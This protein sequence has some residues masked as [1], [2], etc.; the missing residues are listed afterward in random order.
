M[1]EREALKRQIELLQDLINKHR[2]VHGD[3]PI[4]AAER[5]P[6]EAPT[7]ARGR[8]F[9]TSFVHP[10]SSRGRPY[11]HQSCGSWRKTYSLRNNCP[12]ST[13]RQPSAVPSTSLHPS[14]SQYGTGS[15]SAT[16]NSK[17]PEANLSKTASSLSGNLTQKKEGITSR[18]IG[19][20]G[21]ATEQLNT[22]SETQRL[23]SGST[24]MQGDVSKTQEGQ[25][26]GE[27][28]FVILP[29]KKTGASFKFPSSVST[30][31]LHSQCRIQIQNKSS[32]NNKTSP[33]TCKTNKSPTLPTLS[34]NP[35]RPN[36]LSPSKQP[37]HSFQH[38]SSQTLHGQVNAPFLKKSKFTWVNNQTV[39]L[40]LKATSSVSTPISR[41]ARSPTSVLKAAVTVGSPLSGALSK[42]TPFRKFPRKLSPVTVAPKTSMYR[43]V[44]S[45]GVQTKNQRKPLS[46]KTVTVPQ[47]S[48]ER[49]DVDKKLKS[50]F[51]PSARPKRE[52]A[53]SSASST[54][55]SRYRWKAG[56]Q[57]AAGSG[58]GTAAVARRRSTFHWTAE[59]S[60]KGLK[61]G[62]VSPTYPQRAYLRSPPPS[63]FTLHSRMKIIRRTASSVGG[64]EKTST[65]A[66]GKFPP[67]SR[68]HT[69]SRS[70]AGVRRTPSK[71]LVCF[72][73]HKLRKIPPTF[74]K[75]S[76][77]PLSKFKG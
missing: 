35:T 42:K 6:P 21:A 46:P 50:T 63:V 65:L 73:R 32:L 20:S 31:S 37:Q 62:H 1:E 38:A 9:S 30:D 58:T 67:R 55:V 36:L 49:G 26:K 57:I 44:S 68:L 11:D 23:S 54:L 4:T 59:K 19:M 48:L 27:N 72:G 17:S 71:E 18:K 43:W 14:T 51:S 75:T 70:P 40:E 7:A 33:E 41:I 5:R 60:N 29:E 53:A 22:L 16:I 12:Q 15:I 28:R 69:F 76:K 10:Q 52:I 66:S 47:R 3:E 61:M 64:S 8:G 45:S 13:V 34:S 25:Q 39:D 74:S 2:S 56:G 77:K 24:N